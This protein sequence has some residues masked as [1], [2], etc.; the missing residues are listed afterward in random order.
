MMLRAIELHGLYESNDPDVPT[1]CMFLFARDTS[2]TLKDFFHNHIN[3]VGQG[4]GLEQVI[5]FIYDII[6]GVKN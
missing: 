1:F 4:G 5:L 3:D 2:L 6:N